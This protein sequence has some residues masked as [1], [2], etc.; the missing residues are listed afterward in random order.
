MTKLATVEA[1]CPACANTW[2][3]V[4]HA[5]ANVSLD[6]TL[7]ERVLSGDIFKLKCPKCGNVTHAQYDCLYHD[8]SKALMVSLTSAEGLD[9]KIQ[10]LTGA[11]GAIPQRDL[12]TLRIVHSVQDLWE[13]IFIFDAELNDG[14]VELLK[15]VLPGQ[16]EAF[17]GAQLRFQALD[18]AGALAFAVIRPNTKVQFASVPRD[19]YDAVRTKAFSDLEKL[20]SQGGQWLKVDYD[21]IGKFMMSRKPA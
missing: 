13:K 16:D 1:K 11:L 8:M 15:V 6:P 7:K 5:S 9:A 12:Y 17:K 10:G 4:V 20:T 21:L 18:D 19:Y 2:P 3:Q 14:I